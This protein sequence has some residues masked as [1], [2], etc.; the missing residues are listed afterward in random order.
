MGS[1]DGSDFVNVNDQLEWWFP[2]H[3]CR[4]CNDGGSCWN[5]RPKCMSAI[6]R[7][8]S[9]DLNNMW[10]GPGEDFQDGPTGYDFADDAQIWADYPMQ[11]VLIDRY[12]GTWNSNLYNP[13]NPGR[14]PNPGTCVMT[15]FYPISC[16]EI[17]N[18]IDHHWPSPSGGSAADGAADVVIGC[19][20]SSSGTLGCGDQAGQGWASYA[21]TDTVWTQCVWTRVVD[22]SDADC[23]ARI[24]S[25]R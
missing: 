20:T 17:W 11:S 12:T 19:G 3:Y 22:E 15:R 10:A 2:R 9:V 13:G 25:A 6:D 21:N 1:K 5:L 14:N 16:N 4:F 8:Y 23:K 24:D 7:I 18:D